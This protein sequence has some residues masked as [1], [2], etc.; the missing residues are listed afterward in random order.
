[1]IFFFGT[2]IGSFLTMLSYR[3]F[4]KDKNLFHRS[5]C[6]KCKNII[7]YRSLI[8]IFSWL[9]QGGECS[10]C[11]EKISIRYPLIEFGNGLLFLYFYYLFGYIIDINSIYWLS[12]ANLLYLMIIVDLEKMEIPLELQKVLIYFIAVYSIF[13]KQ[14]IVSQIISGI[15]YYIII[16]VVEY[17]T[18]KIKKKD[19]LGGADI[20]LIGLLGSLMGTQF[21]VLFFFLCGLIGFI[22]GL[23]FIIINKLRKLEAVN[24]FPFAPVIII[25]FAIIKIIDLKYYDSFKKIFELLL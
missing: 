22:Y 24:L 23:F 3:L 18:T 16:Q 12:L 5:Q 7:K 1:M 14:M 10:F 2:C 9:F 15:C 13:S 17:L 11:K 21:I 4:E 8:P 25:S 20:I 19:S 6:P